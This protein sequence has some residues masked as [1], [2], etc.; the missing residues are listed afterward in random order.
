MK[1]RIPFTKLVIAGYVALLAACSPA[2]NKIIVK[3]VIDAGLAACIAE[4]PGA[5][6][7][8]LH[9]VCHWTEE[10]GPDVIDLINAQSRG[11]AKLGVVLKPKAA[12]DGGTDAGVRDAGKKD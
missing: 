4:N 3:S 1:A 12:L 2:I 5:D 8:T 7:P 9:E 11:L 6:V 10:F